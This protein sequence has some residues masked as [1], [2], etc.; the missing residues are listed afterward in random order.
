M[1]RKEDFF[2][3]KNEVVGITQE[4]YTNASYI[5]K[6]IDGVACASYNS[7]YVI[8][9]YKH[10][11]LYVSNNPLFLCGCEPEYVCGLG[12]EF[13]LKHVPESEHQFLLTVNHVGFDFFED[14]PITERMDYIISYEFHLQT[15]SN[16][17]L[18]NHK[19]KPVLL[20]KNGHV[21]LAVCVVSLSSHKDAGHI[22]MRRIGSPEEWEYSLAECQWKKLSPIKLSATEKSILR[23]SA[24]GYTM[25]Q[26]VE[27]IGISINT[28]KFHKRRLFRKLQV[29][30]ITEALTYAI[31][32]KL[33]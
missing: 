16:L 33:I 26:I 20:D 32:S 19:L 5:V 1:I 25:E 9:Y 23:L 12:H 4:D 6:A 7:Y 3:P 8:D 18:V 21:W 10:D 17:I 2:T 15:E 22:T 28:V 14:I 31:N 24:Q 27:T 29:E 13:Y 11:F 30:S